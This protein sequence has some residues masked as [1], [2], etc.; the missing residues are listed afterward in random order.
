MSLSCLKPL[1]GS[2]MVFGL[3]HFPVIIYKATCILC[4]YI[5]YLIYFRWLLTLQPRTMLSATVNKLCPLIS[6][7]ALS[8]DWNT[9]FFTWAFLL[10]KALF[11]PGSHACIGWVW[12]TFTGCSFPLQETITT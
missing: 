7:F 8:L 3:N 5:L 6:V 11:L 2:L 9:D 1:N 12:I 4:P 10:D